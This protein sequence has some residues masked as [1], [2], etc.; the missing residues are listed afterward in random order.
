MCVLAGVGHPIEVG[1]LR[2]RSHLA[3]G[4]SRHSRRPGQAWLA[5]RLR[6]PWAGR[7]FGRGCG[8]TD[9]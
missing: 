1:A 4:I 6:K 5:G 8:G 3:G 9:G 7:R 2:D